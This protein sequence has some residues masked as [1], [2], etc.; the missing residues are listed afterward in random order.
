[1][2]VFRRTFLASLFTFSLISAWPA[3]ALAQVAG[4]NPEPAADAEGVRE[5]FVEVLRKYPPAVR[6]VLKLDPSLLANDQ[7][8]APYPEILSFFAK[9]PEVRRSPAYYFEQ[10]ST[11]SSYYYDPRARAWDNMME[12]ISIFAVMVVMVGAFIWLIR[13][14]VDYRRWGRLAK[15]QAE[16]HTKL[17]DRF[18]GNEELLAYVK[19]PAGTRFLQSAPIALDGSPRAV[20]A[21][22]SRIL[23]SMQA[24][25]VLAAAGIGMNFMS[26]RIDPLNADPAFMLSA[27]VLSVGLGFLASAGL[28]YFLSKRLGLLNQPPAETVEG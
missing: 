23:W 19:S 10:V 20:A 13:T 1:M 15:V 22:V 17:L 16:A 18:T 27:I 8:L 12:A 4:R 5:A 24:G 9:H 7:Y 3:P 11:G 14:A 21:P 28:S 2:Q 26:R 25:V 6:Q